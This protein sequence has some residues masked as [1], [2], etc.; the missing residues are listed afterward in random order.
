VPDKGIDVLFATTFRPAL[1]PIQPHRA[2][3]G[4]GGGVG[5]FPSHRASEA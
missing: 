3:T 2:V 1:R 4:V 5:G